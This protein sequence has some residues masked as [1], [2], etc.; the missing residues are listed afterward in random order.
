MVRILDKVSHVFSHLHHLIFIN[1]GEMFTEV[2]QDGHKGGN[3]LD[4]FIW[5]DE[6]DGPKK[7]LE[8]LVDLFLLTYEILI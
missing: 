8:D 5:E 1:Y 4:H 6:E 3:W 2:E 7:D